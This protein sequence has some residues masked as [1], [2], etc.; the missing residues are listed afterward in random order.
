LSLHRKPAIEIPALI[1]QLKYKTSVASALRAA[2][3]CQGL[4][5]DATFMLRLGFFSIHSIK[6]TLITI[7][8]LP[9]DFNLVLP[10]GNRIGDTVRW[11]K[12][13]CTILLSR[14]AVKY[15]LSKNMSTGAYKTGTVHVLHRTSMR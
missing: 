5:R 10:S 9:L 4:D 8:A 7:S 15:Q 2:I 6:A 12:Q 14:P 13:L 3:T 11:R 1:E